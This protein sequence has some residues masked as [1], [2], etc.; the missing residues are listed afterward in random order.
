MPKTCKL[1]SKWWKFAKFGHTVSNNRKSLNLGLN[2]HDPHSLPNGSMIFRS[3]KSL[4]YFNLIFF[5]SH[6]HPYDFY[7]CHQ[8]SWTLTQPTVWPDWVI[9]WTLGN[10]SKAVAIISLHKSLTFLGNF[11]K[12][13]KIF[14]FSSEIIFGQ[15]L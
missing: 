6:F 15:L 5:T 14:N 1:L 4:S 12:G 7:W 13:V 3:K 9:Y 11:W 2:L 10:F 8:S